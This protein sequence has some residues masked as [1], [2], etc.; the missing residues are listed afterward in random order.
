M[1]VYT[2]EAQSG[3]MIFEYNVGWV[4]KAIFD[5]WWK[6]LK[7]TLNSIEMYSA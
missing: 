4:N 6:H 2:Y 3:V 7:F 5:M 1:V